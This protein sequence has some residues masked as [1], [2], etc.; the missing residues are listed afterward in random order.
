MDYGIL[1]V[2]PPL[3]AILLAL[4]TKQTV[5]SLFLGLWIELPL[6]LIGTQLSDFQK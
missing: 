4:V 3:V 6:S 1:S 2:I 5:F